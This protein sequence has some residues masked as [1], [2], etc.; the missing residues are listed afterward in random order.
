MASDRD[1]LQSFKEKLLGSK[2]KWAE[3][4]RLLTG[5]PDAAKVQR[6]PPGQREVKNWPVLDLGIKPK[7]A[8]QDWRLTIDGAVARP[9]V[10]DFATFMAQPQIDDVSDIHCV[11]AWSRYDNHWRGVSAQH[12]LSQV[13]PLASARHV[14]LH[15]H[16]GD[17]KSVV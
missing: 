11:T 7:I 16:D 10:W 13:Q 3:E 6:L 1:L 17:R 9:V 2:K 4:G 12:L 15:S 14:I 8:T 5:R